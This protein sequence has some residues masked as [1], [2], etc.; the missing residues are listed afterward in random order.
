M[1]KV[2]DVSQKPDDHPVKKKGRPKKSIFKASIE[3][4]SL[5]E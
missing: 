5:Y 2:E 3:D 4:L 1:G